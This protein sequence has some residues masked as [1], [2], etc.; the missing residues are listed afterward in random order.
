MQRTSG[1]SMKSVAGLRRDD[2]AASAIGPLATARPL[3]IAGIPIG[4]GPVTAALEQTVGHQRLEP[5]R[6]H[7]ASDAQVSGHLPVAAQAV[8]GLA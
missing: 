1:A 4:L 8:E 6:Q 3:H 5:R 7:V 2:A